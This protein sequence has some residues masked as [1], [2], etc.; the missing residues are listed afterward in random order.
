MNRTPTDRSVSCSGVSRSVNGTDTTGPSGI[1]ANATKAAVAEMTG[2]RMK[3]TLSAAF[4]TMSS[5]SAS[6]MPSAS[7]CSRPNGPWYFGPIRC[8]M[9]ATT[10]RS[11]QM[12]S[13]VISTSRTKMSTALRPMTHH[14]SVPKADRSSA[15]S[16][17]SPLMPVLSAC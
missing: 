5:L 6:L 14:G 13:R 12:V 2:A 3:T 9:R 17:V 11:P 15:A 10:L 7:D 16:R 1:T 4:G 8:C